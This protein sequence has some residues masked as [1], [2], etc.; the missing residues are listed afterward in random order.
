MR[1][2]SDSSLMKNLF[3]LFIFFVVLVP[4]LV[5]SASDQIYKELAVFTQILD[6]IDKQYVKDPD[7]KKLVLGAI[8]GMLSALDSHTVYFPP[9]VYKEFKSDTSGRFGGV[10]IEVTAK[11]GGLVI[12][13]PIDG[14][15]AHAA[16][17]KSGDRILSIEGKSAKNMTLMDSVKLMR[18]PVGKKVHFV[19]LSEGQTKPRQVVV[20]R[21]IIQVASV[22]TEDLG[23]G[24]AYFRITTFQEDTAKEFKKVLQNFKSQDGK[25]LQGLVLDLRD[26]PGGLLFEAVKISNFFIEKGIIVSTK[27]RVQEEEVIRAKANAAIFKKLPVVILINNGSA[28]AAEI[29]AGA[30]QDNGRAKLFGTKTFGKG[31]VQTVVDL[32]GGAALKFTVAYY[33]TPKHQIIDG[34]GIEP[35]VLLDEKTFLKKIDKLPAAERKNKKFKTGTPEFQDALS[36]FQKKQA[37]DFLKK[38]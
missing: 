22:K 35:D 23:D 34:K 24:Y 14:S 36:D 13:A 31:S 12:V 9:E 21:E 5:F 20:T 15:P 17:L 10:G 11:D 33:H 30:M 37:T 19:V 2:K 32:T 38:M 6:I 27:G 25:V 1:A 29:V 16:G 4:R 7:E 18:G 8:Q 3:S 28:S 26:N